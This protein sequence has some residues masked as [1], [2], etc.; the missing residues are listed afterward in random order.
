MNY[1]IQVKTHQGFFE[2]SQLQTSKEYAEERVTAVAIGGEYAAVRWVSLDANGDIAQAGDWNGYRMGD[3]TRPRD[4]GPYA[5]SSSRVSLA[6]I[7][8]YRSQIESLEAGQSA[9]QELLREL[10]L[11][12]NEVATY[13]ECG[14]LR[15]ETLAALMADQA[16]EIKNIDAGEKARR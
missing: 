4:A 16:Q 6:Q 12:R 2:F 9:T 7:A 15:M 5:A 3:S 14:I 13:R 8:A 11:L 1:F 10:D